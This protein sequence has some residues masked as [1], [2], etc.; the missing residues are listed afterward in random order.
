[1]SPHL[2]PDHS[3]IDPMSPAAT[4]SGFCKNSL[5]K[6]A[7]PDRDSSL[8]DLLCNTLGGGVAAAA[9]ITWQNRRISNQ[10]EQEG[11]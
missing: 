4:D 3:K 9:V 8:L 6:S 10:S 5:Q 11:C 1:M 2:K 7:V